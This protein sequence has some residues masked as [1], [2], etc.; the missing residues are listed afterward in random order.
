[1]SL[2]IRLCVLHLFQT[3]TTWL[4]HADVH[5]VPVLRSCQMPIRIWLYVYHMHTLAEIALG[6][7]AR[8]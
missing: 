7:R 4:V 6:T 5:V 3:V 8:W 2:W 1:M